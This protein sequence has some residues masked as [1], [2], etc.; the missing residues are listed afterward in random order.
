MAENGR[1]AA[2][3]ATKKT[4][5][6]SVQDYSKTVRPQTVYKAADLITKEENA[7]SVFIEVVI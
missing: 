3:R 6:A 7:A 4:T 1:R 2:R 5:T